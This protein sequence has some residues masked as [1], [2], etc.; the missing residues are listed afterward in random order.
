[1][2]KEIYQNNNIL[3]ELRGLGDGSTEYW[4]QCGQA[5]LMLD[6]NDLLDLSEILNAACMEIWRRDGH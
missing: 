1:M 6:Q 5:G 3:I 4:V 2:N